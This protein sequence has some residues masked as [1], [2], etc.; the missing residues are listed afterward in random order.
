VTEEDNKKVSH[1]GQCPTLLP[2]EAHCSQHISD[3]FM[4]IH[5]LVTP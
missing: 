3:S 1:Y 2:L 5:F 4:S